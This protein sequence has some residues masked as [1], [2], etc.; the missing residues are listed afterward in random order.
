MSHIDR[1]AFLTLGVS[2][3]AAAL[4][5]RPASGAQ[6][7]TVQQVIDRIQKTLGV[8]WRAETVDTFKAGNPATTVRGIA[9]TVMATLSVLERAAASNRNLIITHEPTFYGHTDATT[10]IEADPL[11]QHKA[12]VIK[13]HDMVVW[14]FHDHWHMRRPEPM[15]EG[16]LRAVEWDKYPFVN[17]VCTIPEATLEDVARHVQRKMSI[18]APR[19][20]GER[21]TKIAK[22][23]FMPGYGQPQGMMQALRDA[24]LVI[25]GEQREWEGLFYAHDAVSSKRPK[26]VIVLGHAISE[27]PGMKLC[28]DWL[29]TFIPE[30]PVELIPAGEPFWSPQSAPAFVRLFDGTLDGWV[31]ENTQANNI[32]VAN[33]LLRVEG[34][35]GWL[36]SANQY[37]N[38][39]LRVECRFLTDDA[40]SGIFL[41]AP[42]PASNIFMR[43][44]PANAYQ[45]QARDMSRNKTTNPFWV[46]NLYRHRVAPG[47]TQF[48]GEAAMKAVKPTGEWQL[49]EIDADDDKIAVRLNGVPITRASNIVNPRGHIGI[50]AETGALEYRTIEISE[51]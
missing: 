31:I 12:A 5:A 23:I 33:G 4:A 39:T 19:V 13:K 8:Q 50:Q 47:E 34:P 45:V 40:D 36:R 15:T 42:G 6:S 43:G 30:V 2:A 46:G 1:R 44:W 49:F 25:C 35:Q 11:Y 18:R 24:D 48:D 32:T 51:R 38:F 20:I 22:V 27:E 16:F 14:R 9:T 37:G 28:A 17:R 29:K 7:L 21:T 41:R 10:E 26:G 3:A